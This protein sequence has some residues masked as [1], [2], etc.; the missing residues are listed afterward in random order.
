MGRFISIGHT[1]HLAPPFVWKP[2]AVEPRFVKVAAPV[3]TAP[4]PEPTIKAPQPVFMPTVDD[5][6]APE[7]VPEPRPLPS[8]ADM[9]VPTPTPPADTMTM[10]T[11]EPFP[12]P[13]QKTTVEDMPPRT[14]LSQNLLSVRRKL[15]LTPE[16]FSRP[17]IEDSEGLINRLEAG[18]SRPSAEISNLIC[19]TWGITASYLFSGTGAM[20]L[21]DE[22]ES[23]EKYIVLLI[24]LLKTYLSVVTF[25]RKGNQ[26]WKGSLVD[27]LARIIDVK[28]LDGRR[29]SRIVRV[30]YDYLDVDQ[31]ALVLERFGR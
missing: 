2:R 23:R 31:F 5:L 8:V 16:E 18:F 12:S 25:D 13:K 26:Y 29:M 3:L 22:T 6:T 14:P 20:F 1:E 4:M 19:D 27:D 15:N 17:I 24:K 21:K 28:K 9:T 30:L 10:Y 11:P 7:P